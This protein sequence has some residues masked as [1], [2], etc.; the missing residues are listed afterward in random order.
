MEHLPKKIHHNGISY[1]LMGD[2]YI[3]DLRLP[4]ESRPIGRWGRMHKAFLQE[5]RPGQYNELLLSG[6]LWTYLADLNGQA[7]DRLVCIISQMQAAEGVTEELKARNWL[8]W[9]QSMNSIRSRAEE[10]I[11]SE[12]IFV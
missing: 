3:P 7:N 4:E 2:Y 11:C 6:K 1:T 9:V 10:I 12:M 5:H 8:C